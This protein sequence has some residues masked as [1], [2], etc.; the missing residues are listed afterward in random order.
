MMR[1]IGL[2]VTEDRISE[3]KQ[4]NSIEVSSKY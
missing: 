3:F 1:V 2:R 4:E